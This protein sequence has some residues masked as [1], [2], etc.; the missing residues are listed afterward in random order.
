MEP[1]L[2]SVNLGLWVRSIL[3]RSASCYHNIY[4]SIYYSAFSYLPTGSKYHVM[5][6]NNCSLDIFERKGESSRLGQIDL[7][8][9]KALSI[10]WMQMD[11]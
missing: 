10:H 2:L 7:Y 4:W 1:G 6:T 11:G 8:S 3:S 9:F 5:C